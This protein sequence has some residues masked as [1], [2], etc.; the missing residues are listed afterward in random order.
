MKARHPPGLLLMAG[1]CLSCSKNEII[2]EIS[3]C[4]PLPTSLLDG[5]FRG[6]GFEHKVK[7]RVL[8]NALE[9]AMQITIEL[10]QQQTNK[11]EWGH[12]FDVLSLR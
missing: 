3:E 5:T 2:V 4:T 6:L 7:L 8:H 12:I 11:K 9:M 1:M 10:Q